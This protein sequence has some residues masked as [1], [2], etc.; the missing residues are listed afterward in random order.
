MTD[1]LIE[2]AALMTIGAIP[3]FLVGWGYGYN[4]GVR[5][6]ID[7]WKGETHPKKKDDTP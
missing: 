6:V 1:K 2:V 5:R 3:G 4:A 7:L